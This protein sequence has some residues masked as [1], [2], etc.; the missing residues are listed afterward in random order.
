MTSP[1]PAR[2]RDGFGNDAAT[3]MPD[4]R[5][6]FSARRKKNSTSRAARLVCKLL[7]GTEITRGL[8]RPMLAGTLVGEVEDGVC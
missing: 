6:I 3:R 4:E 1:S 5:K 7:A 8:H 2:S